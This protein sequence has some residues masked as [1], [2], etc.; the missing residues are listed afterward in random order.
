M[1]EHWSTPNGC[2]A[3]CPVREA[4]VVSAPVVVT[5][6][7]DRYTY[8]QAMYVGDD[9]RQTSGSAIQASAVAGQLDGVP[10][11]LRFVLTELGPAQAWPSRLHDCRLAACAS[12][13]ITVV[14]DTVSRLVAIYADGRLLRVDPYLTMY[15]REPHMAITMQT[16]LAR[17]AEFP[18]QLCDVKPLCDV[19]FA[20]SNDGEKTPS[21]AEKTCT[22][23][24]ITSRE[25]AAAFVEKNKR[26]PHAIDYADAGYDQGSQ[27]A[28]T[29]VGGCVLRD[30]CNGHH[31]DRNCYTQ[32]LQD[33]IVMFSTKRAEPKQEDRPTTVK[34]LLSRILKLESQCRNNGKVPTIVRIPL[35]AESLLL[36]GA[37]FGEVRQAFRWQAGSW[38]PQSIYGLQCI[39]ETEEL[40]VE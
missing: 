24:K 15:P 39:W 4:D 36:C 30:A 34:D 3:D 12:A 23:A 29:T 27:C 31:C 22:V 35:W 26:F 33:Y 18:K 6:V 32:Q 1:S 37:H 13:S 38:R 2:H 20:A 17:Y 25:W 9:L 7:Q 16:A 10:A 8:L 28:C 19:A 21:P 40:V 14:Q 11:V 5:I